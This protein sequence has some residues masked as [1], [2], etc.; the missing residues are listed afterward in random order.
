MPPG[1]QA[2]RWYGL[3]TANRLNQRWRAG[4]PSAEPESAGVFLTQWD[5]FHRGAE[6]GVLQ[7]WLPC[8]PTDWCYWLVGASP[9]FSAT[10]T[11]ALTPGLWDAGLAGFVIDSDAVAIRCAYSG[12]ASSQGGGSGCPAGADDG[13]AAVSTNETSADG[14]F[15]PLQWCT[16]RSPSGDGG[17]AWRPEQLIDAMSQQVHLSPVGSYNQRHS[18]NE[19]VCN[20]MPFVDRLPHAVEALFVLSTSSTEMVTRARDVRD[21]FI[22]D[23]GLT[24][25]D[26]PPVVVYDPDGSPT[27]PFRFL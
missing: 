24:Q 7:L 12:D 8:Q 17:C 13:I 26:A 6:S 5:A 10:V 16:A 4:R 3:E 14:K 20:Y 1:Q 19:L 11:N 15:V 27:A 22:R 21:A 25:L 2:S 18:Y 9:R 23:F